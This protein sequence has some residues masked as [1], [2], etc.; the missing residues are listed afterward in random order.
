TLT[1]SFTGPI[2]IAPPNRAYRYGSLTV[3]PDGTANLGTRVV[4][5]SM[6]QVLY[7]LG[8]MPALWPTEALKAQSIAGRTFAQKRRAAGGDLRAWMDI[9]YIGYDMETGGYFDRWKAAVD[10]TAG[11]VVTYNGALIDALYSASSGGYTENSEYVFVS[12]LPYLRAIPDPDDLVTGNPFATWTKTY[13]AAEIGA[14]FGVGTATAV[15]ITGNI[16]VSGRTNRATIHIVGT[17]ATKDVSSS[18]FRSTVA[19]KDPSRALISPKFTIE[20][21]PAPTSTPRTPVLPVGVITVAKADGHVIT[22]AG[23]VYDPDGPPTMRVVSTMGT[24]TA[25]RTV[26]AAAGKWSVSWTGAAGTRK[27]CVSA[28]DVPTGTAVSLGCKSVTVK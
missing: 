19:A 25:V 27:I 6:A 23:T 14:W 18:S 21:Y 20:P 7:G 28:L 5:L 9:A 11:Q 16:G 12:A 10:G 17:T 2:R 13:T 24:T 15:Q 1:I 22:V 4:G 3:V 8:E 26:K